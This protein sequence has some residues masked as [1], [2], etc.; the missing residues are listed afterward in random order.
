[1]TTISMRLFGAACAISLA[2]PAMAQ[3]AAEPGDDLA[4]PETNNAAETASRAN[5]ARW[6]ADGDGTISGA[7]W[8]AGWDE[9][10]LFAQWDE[11]GD[12]NL[13]SEELARGFLDRYD[14]DGSGAIEEYEQGELG[15]EMGAD[16]FFAPA[17]G[18][19]RSR[20]RDAA[21]AAAGPAGGQSVLGSRTSCS[22]AR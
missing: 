2:F 11:N 13:T 12:G 7:E 10:D 20:W 14:E 19:F 4:T 17:G 18:R 15:R 5:S 8:Q 9:R 21:A 22:G 16:G 3:E 1:M 6:D